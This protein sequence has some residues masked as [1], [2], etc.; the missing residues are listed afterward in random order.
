MAEV[1]RWCDQRV[2]PP[3]RDKLRIEC[4]VTPRHLTIVECRPPWRERIGPEWTRM[5]VARLHYTRAHRIWSLYW[6]DRNGRFHRYDRLT[7]SPGV[8]AL[9]R[10]IEQD[11]TAIFWG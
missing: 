3:V 6:R 4:E 5:P 10:E 11:A 7:P 8:D 9:L 1:R 2:P